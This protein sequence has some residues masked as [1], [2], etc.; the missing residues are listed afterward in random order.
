MAINAALFDK[1]ACGIGIEG[2][3][4]YRRKW[5][6]DLKTFH[7]TPVKDWSEH[8]G[9]SWRYLGLAWREVKPPPEKKAK[10]KELIYEVK[11]GRVVGN[12]SVKEAVDAMVKRRRRDD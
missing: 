11:D 1:D 12:M 2:L 8:I 7:K 10:P 4:S 9:S 6:D 5:D 3:K